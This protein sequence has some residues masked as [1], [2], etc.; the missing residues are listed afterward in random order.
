MIVERILKECWTI[1]E[2]FLHYCGRI[3]ERLLHDC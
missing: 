2:W 3:F 1:D